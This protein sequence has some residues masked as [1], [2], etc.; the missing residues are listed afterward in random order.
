MAGTAAGL[1]P[2]TVRPIATSNNRA[3][4]PN[5]P[6]TRSTAKALFKVVRA[7]PGVVAQA[8]ALTSEVEP[9]ASAA[10]LAAAGAGVANRL[11]KIQPHGVSLRL[12]AELALEHPQA[13]AMRVIVATAN[14][15]KGLATCCNQAA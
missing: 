9:K 1:D 7:Q 4:S 3:H 14:R 15:C 10:E 8:V 6:R 12:L 5:S 11:L 13:N 2:R